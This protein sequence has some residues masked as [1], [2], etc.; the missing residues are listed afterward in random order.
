MMVDQMVQRKRSVNTSDGF[1]K[2]PR[3]FNTFGEEQTVDSE[4]LPQI[5]SVS[6]FLDVWYKY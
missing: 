5:P 3:R 6:H 1:V 4:D 2:P